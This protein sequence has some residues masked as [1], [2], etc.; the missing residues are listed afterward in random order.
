MKITGGTIGEQTTNVALEC[1]LEL[2]VGTRGEFHFVGFLEEK[3]DVFPHFFYF[4]DKFRWSLTDWFSLQRLQN[5][6]PSP[7]MHTS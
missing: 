6:G 2:P 1:L 3:L 5:V 7:T 4:F